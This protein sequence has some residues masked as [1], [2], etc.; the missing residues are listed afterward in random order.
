VREDRE[1]GEGDKERGRI[2]REKGERER[3]GG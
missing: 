2:W 1:K 3:E